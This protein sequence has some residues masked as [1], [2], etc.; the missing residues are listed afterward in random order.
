MQERRLGFEIIK[1]S[2]LFKAKLSEKLSC[3]EQLKDFPKQYA[4]ILGFLYRRKD[5][6]TCQKDLQNAFCM[7]RATISKI[8]TQL[9][10]MDYIQRKPVKGDKRLN[11]II[12]TDKGNELELEM[13]KQ[14]ASFEKDFISK[15]TDD[16]I[17]D[18]FYLIDKLTSVMQKS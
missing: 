16:E 3:N 2:N 17:K 5:E 8:L 12:L 11:C 18:M 14:I 9:E 10:E 6:I 4:W 1:M 15:F 7:N 13:R